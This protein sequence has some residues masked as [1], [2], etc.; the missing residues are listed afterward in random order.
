MSIFGRSTPK[1]QYDYNIKQLNSKI[2][3]VLS[4]KY[5]IESEI[6]EL[7]NKIAEKS[8]PSLIGRLAQRTPFVNS[9][10]TLRTVL[11]E[12]ERELAKLNDNIKKTQ[13]NKNNRTAQH[14]ANFNRRRAIAIANKERR[15]VTQTSAVAS[16]GGVNK[17]KTH[18]RRTNKRNKTKRNRN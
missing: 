11:S 7:T 2:D 14:K 16:Y 5:I 8:N 4:R 3:Q 6:L 17:R 18:K 12:K 1:G 15:G 9:A 10:D 13:I